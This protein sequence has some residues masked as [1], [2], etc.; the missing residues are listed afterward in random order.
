MYRDSDRSCLIRDRSGDSLPDPPCSV[1]RKLIAFRII[2]FLYCFNKSQI[3]F[4]NEV[5]ERKSSVQISSC[6]TDYES[7]I[8]L[9]QFLLS[10]LVSLFDP[11]R[12]F[13]FFFC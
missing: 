11:D 8:A 4:L 1:C 5:K 6:N 12:K 2:K 7:E 9:A 10:F 13:A 3:T